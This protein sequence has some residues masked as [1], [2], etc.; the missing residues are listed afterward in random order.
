MS[1]IRVSGGKNRGKISRVY[2]SSNY[3]VSAP[4]INRGNNERKY[5]THIIQLAKSH[6]HSKNYKKYISKTKKHGNRLAEKTLIKILKAYQD[7]LL[8]GKKQKKQSKAEYI[9]NNLEKNLKKYKVSQSTL[10]K[11]LKYDSQYSKKLVKKDK[12]RKKKINNRGNS[13]QKTSKI[14]QAIA[15]NSTYFLQIINF[16]YQEV[17]EDEVSHFIKSINKNRK[18]LSDNLI[19]NIILAYQDTLN[20]SISKKQRKKLVNDKLESNL[21]RK[22]VHPDTIKVILQLDSNHTN[23]SVA[24]QA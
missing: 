8:G 2:G 22:G 7:T 16:S 6:V 5:Y 23:R 9:S 3:V 18:I 15:D 24:K 10:Q 4:N 19:R 11:I 14:S 20:K 17:N 21:L 12:T 1:I 13:K